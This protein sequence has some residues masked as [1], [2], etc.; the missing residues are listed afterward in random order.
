MSDMRSDISTYM[1][2]CSLQ[3]LAYVSF[4][5][6]L[7]AIDTGTG[8]PFVN[9]EALIKNFAVL[10]ANNPD[11]LPPDFTVCSATTTM[12]FSSYIHPFQLLHSNGKPW[13]S[14]GFVMPMQKSKKN[15][16]MVFFVSFTDNLSDLSG[17]TH[18]CNE[19]LLYR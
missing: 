14:V 8:F 5:V 4:G 12:A 6:A 10:D 19:C 18:I 11:D 7:Q 15:H 2:S 16:R 17:K 9:N 3:L 1:Y 13:I